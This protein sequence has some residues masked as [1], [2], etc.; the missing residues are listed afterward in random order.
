MAQLCVYV[1]NEVP[2]QMLEDVGE[3]TG[4]EVTGRTVSGEGGVVIEEQCVVMFYTVEGKLDRGRVR[5]PMSSIGGVDEGLH[6]ITM[7]TRA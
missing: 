5:I 3:L 1:S 7:G 6:T 2:D 4:I